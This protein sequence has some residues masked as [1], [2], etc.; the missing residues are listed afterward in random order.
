MEIRKETR[1]IY[2]GGQD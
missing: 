2:T 1:E